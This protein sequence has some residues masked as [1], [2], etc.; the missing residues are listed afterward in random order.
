M[1]SSLGFRKISIIVFPLILYG[2]ISFIFFGLKLFPHFSEYCSGTSLDVYTNLWILNWWPYALIHHIHPLLTDFVWAPF[3]YNLAETNLA[4]GFSLLLA[5]VTLFFGPIVANNILNISLTAISAYAAFFL[6]RFISRGAILASLVGGYIYGFSSYQLAHTY[7][8]HLD[9][10]SIFLFP[11]IILSCLYYIKNRLTTLGFLLFTTICLVFQF[12]I[13]V[14]LFVTSAICFFIALVSFYIC[15]AEYR[16]RLAEI[17]YLLLWS[18]VL[19]LVIVSPFLFYFYAYKMSVFEKLDYVFANDLLNFI[20]PTKITWLGGNYFANI[21]QHFRG[22]IYEWD[23]YVGL[24]LI[25][26]FILFI[27][28][29]WPDK[30]CRSLIL[31]T[32]IFAIFSLGPIIRLNGR[33]IIYSPYYLFNFFPVLKYALPSRFSLYTFLCLATMVVLWLCKSKINY[34]IKCFLVG[35]TIIFLLPNPALISSITKPDIPLFIKNQ[36]YKKLLHKNDIILFLPQDEMGGYDQELY[37]QVKSNMYFRILG[38]QISGVSLRY[39]YDPVWNSLH[40]M[41]FSPEVIAAFKSFLLNSQVAAVFVDK[42]AASKF[43][44]LL[45]ALNIKPISMGKFF[46]FKIKSHKNKLLFINAL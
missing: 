34:G 32:F 38:G 21:S 17:I 40:S 28:E 26:I 23:T 30:I 20:V 39:F 6:F 46:I 2:I 35:L 13:G 43:Q 25:T 31:I 5:P 27:K 4:H 1:K 8:A 3:G 19:T 12:S 18:Y 11:L 22:N 36:N 29:F 33:E 37:W 10:I 44:P 14:E 9:L 45:S 16:E 24:P 42:K 41:K 15:L 7:T